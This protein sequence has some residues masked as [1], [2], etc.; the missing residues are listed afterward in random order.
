[1]QSSKIFNS[2]L[3]AIDEPFKSVKLILKFLG[4]F[5][6]FILAAYALIS[7]FINSLNLSTYGISGLL[8]IV[9]LPIVILLLLFFNAYSTRRELKIKKWTISVINISVIL[10]LL[11]LAVW[12]HLFK[13]SSELYFNSEGY[14]YSVR[15]FNND[16]KQVFAGKPNC[17]DADC[18]K[19]FEEPL[20]LDPFAILP[21]ALF[22][23]P[24]RISNGKY[25][26]EIIYGRNDYLDTLYQE[27]VIPSSL[28]TLNIRSRHL[29]NKIIIN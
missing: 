28:D 21:T 15:I 20:P 6:G 14:I 3:D 9:F 17:L 26:I 8:F 18:L 24:K 1:M 4:S 10:F 22:K 2:F 12:L 23:L 16:L 29:K 27:L 13:R 25:S 5:Y 11:A 19:K 7:L